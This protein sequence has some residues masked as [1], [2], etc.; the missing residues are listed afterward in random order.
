MLRATTAI[1]LDAAGV[2]LDTSVMAAQW[3]RLVGEF[4][5]PRLGG[6][7]AR[8]GPANA[9]AAERLWARYRDPGGTPRETHGRLRRLWLRE[10]CEHVGVPVP[11]D[12]ERLVWEAHDW[13]CERVVA[14]SPEV[15]ETLRQLKAAGFRLFTATGQPSAEIAG[16]LRGMGVR[17]LFE[18]TYGTD[19]VDRWK[20]NSGF[21]RKI[22][23]DSGV[24]PEDA[25]TV[26][27]LPKALDWAR[28]AGFRTF[29]VAP[30]GTADG[31]HERIAALSELPSRLVR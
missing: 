27:D 11:R 9:Y 13:I 4:F 15:P 14:S 23:D 29:I 25:V 28:R 6:D 30:E 7:P 2:L 20:T 8:W 5:A 16:Y 24:R 18:A 26:D 22:L 3:Q 1:F 12:A 17:D 31:G 21:Y 19:L 10:M